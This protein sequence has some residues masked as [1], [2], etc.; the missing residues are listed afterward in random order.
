M[1]DDKKPL[2]PGPELD[3]RIAAEWS[4]P[5]AQYSSDIGAAMELF[6]ELGEY[7][8]PDYPGGHGY[9]KPVVGLEWYEH[10]GIARATIGRRKSLEGGASV[11]VYECECPCR[12]AMPG[13]GRT[14]ALA[15]SR[16]A[17]AVKDQEKRP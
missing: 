8:S 10:D 2:S 1:S 5:P 3:A 12:G 7:R 11:T 13:F 6:R 15:I 9:Y 17:C 4:L 16:L 14:M